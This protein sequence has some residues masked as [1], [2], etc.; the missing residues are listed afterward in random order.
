MTKET[1]LPQPILQTT[2]VGSLP[3]P[4]WLAQPNKLWA[5]WRLEGAELAEGK[6]DAVLVEASPLI[7]AHL[8]TDFRGCSSLR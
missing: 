3:K 6:R 2:I 1:P 7:R 5:P 8:P 4:S